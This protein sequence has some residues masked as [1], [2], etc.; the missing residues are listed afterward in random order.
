VCWSGGIGDRL[1]LPTTMH[2]GRGLPPGG[3]VTD[4]DGICTFCTTFS[5]TCFFRSYSAQDTCVHVTKIVRFDWS[6]VISAGIVCIKTVVIGCQVCCESFFYCIQVAF[7]PMQIFCGRFLKMCHVY[8]TPSACK[9][10]ASDCCCCC[11]CVVAVM[12]AFI[13]MMIIMS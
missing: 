13:I 12:F 11:G 3:A 2:N 5:C 9:S 6:P 1:A 8:N 10:Q 7:F 4:D